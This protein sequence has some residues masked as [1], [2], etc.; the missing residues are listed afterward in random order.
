MKKW[1]KPWVTKTDLLSYR[2][3]QKKGCVNCTEFTEI[4]NLA[5]PSVSHHIK[6]LVDSGLINSDKEGRFV[7]LCINRENIEEFNAFLNDINKF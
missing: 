1:P 7:K 3:L 5:Q 6:I 2:R 4:I